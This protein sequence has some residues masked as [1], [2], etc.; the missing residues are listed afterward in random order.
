M[1][2]RNI[3]NKDEDVLR[4]KSREVTVFDDKLS[5]LVD[6][7]F[8]TL[9]KADGAGLAAPQ[10]GILRRVVVIDVGDGP[11]E[12][13][14]PE[15]VK[16]S[17]KQHEVEGCLSCPN[18]WGYVVR[19]AKVKCRAKNRRGETVEYNA[20]G[21]FARCICHELDHLEGRL[22]IDVSDRMLTPEEV[23]EM[24]NGRG[25]SD[26]KKKKKHK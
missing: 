17:G 19:P 23:D 14:N 18:D 24:L 3:L 20:E 5:A 2:I 26:G 6:D 7:M 9:K 22:F 1:A 16:T 8:D 10:V 11:I 12:L 15:I 21:L 13:I 4:K 25:G